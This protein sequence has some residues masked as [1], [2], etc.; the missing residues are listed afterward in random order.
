MLFFVYIRALRLASDLLKVVA[1]KV[2]IREDILKGN[3]EVI[4]NIS[5]FS[6]KEKWVISAVLLIG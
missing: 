4:N 6:N 1:V 3:K 5:S 2:G